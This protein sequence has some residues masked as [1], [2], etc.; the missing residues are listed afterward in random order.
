MLQTTIDAEFPQVDGRSY[1]QGV[2]ILDRM[3][4]TALGLAGAAEMVIDQ[5]KFTRKTLCN[6]TI[7]ALVGDGA[8][9]PAGAN[10]V[11]LGR[12]GD[13]P[14]VAAYTADP[15]RPVTLRETS[16][17]YPFRDLAF[18]GAWGGRLIL[19]AGDP[20]TVLW[21]MIEANKRCMR[22][23][24]R[25]AHDAP[26]AN[27]VIELVYAE[28][29]DFTPAMVRPGSVVEIVTLAVRQALGRD[30]VM[31]ELRYERPDGAP[32]AFR[33]NFSAQPPGGTA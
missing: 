21:A 29:I 20:G 14:A 19:D 25:R 31:N 6:G 13:V 26:E 30:Y 22:D 33:Y 9:A 24:F 27:P 5:A 8:A 15:A 12:V 28:A 4:E 11:I 23:G 17:P 7:T 10:A 16:A 32:G 3:A 2:T 18:D 1:I